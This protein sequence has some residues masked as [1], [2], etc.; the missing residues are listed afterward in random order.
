ME[1]GHQRH[2]PGRLTGSPRR[3]D[4]VGRWVSAWNAATPSEV[5]GINIGQFLSAA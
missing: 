4:G 2:D 3:G 5:K 1:P